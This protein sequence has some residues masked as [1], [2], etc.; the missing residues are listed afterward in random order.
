MTTFHTIY[1]W[2]VKWFVSNLGPTEALPLVMVIMVQKE[3]T[4]KYVK[5][6]VVGRIFL[7]T[8]EVAVR[9]DTIVMID[10]FQVNM[11]SWMV[12]FLR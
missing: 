5:Q 1:F 8:R 6:E 10:I 4:D 11:T 9:I 3:L 2:L 12:I 7:L